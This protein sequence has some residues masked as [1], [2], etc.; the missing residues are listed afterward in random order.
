MFKIIMFQTKTLDY[1]LKIKFGHWI[2][3][4]VSDFEI[5]VLDF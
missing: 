5:R 4:I 2:L 1:V 3:D